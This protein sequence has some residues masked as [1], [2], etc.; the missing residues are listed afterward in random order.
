MVLTLTK[1]FR[2]K[3]PGDFWALHLMAFSGVALAALLD[4][5]FLLS[6]LLFGYLACTPWSLACFYVYRETEQAKRNV[7]APK[8]PAPAPMPLLPWRW[9]GLP[10]RPGGRW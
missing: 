6:F 5:D 2:P 8:A 10:R 1:L 9:L 4:S 3:T 7:A